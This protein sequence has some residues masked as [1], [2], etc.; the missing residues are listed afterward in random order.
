MPNPESGTLLSATGAAWAMI[1]ETIKY[2]LRRTE[3]DVYEIE[4]DREGK[5]KKMRRYMVKT[6]DNT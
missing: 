3:I 4:E 6:V 5:A 2:P 1:T